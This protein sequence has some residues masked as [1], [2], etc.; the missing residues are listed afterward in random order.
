MMD[1]PMLTASI[2]CEDVLRTQVID[3]RVTLHRVLF[4]VYADSFPAVL[5]RL[6]IANI[7]RGG[8]GEFTDR[9]RILTPSAR[10]TAEAE[11]SFVAAR[12]GSHTQMFLFPNLILPEPGDYAVEIYRNEQ[13]LMTYSLIVVDTSDLEEEA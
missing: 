13:L 8:H 11:G 12:Q 1:A 3:G 9:T 4:D 7:W 10:V 5:P 2:P 6:V